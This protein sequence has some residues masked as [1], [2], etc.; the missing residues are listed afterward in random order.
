MKCIL[1]FQALATP[2][3]YQMLWIGSPKSFL[4]LNVAASPLL[5][6]DRA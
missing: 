6:L 1:I 4:V 3:M 5:V 2:I